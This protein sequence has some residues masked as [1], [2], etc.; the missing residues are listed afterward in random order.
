MKRVTRVRARWMVIGAIALLGVST[1][2][3]ADCHSNPDQPFCGTEI[4]PHWLDDCDQVQAAEKSF[5]ETFQYQRYG[6]IETLFMKLTQGLDQARKKKNVF[7]EALM[8]GRLGWTYLWF[9]NEYLYA[10]SSPTPPD[11]PPGL[12]ALKLKVPGPIDRPLQTKSL[13]A[14]NKK[15]LAN[16]P[17]LTPT[18]GSITS[19]TGVSIA[20]QYFHKATMLIMDVAANTTK[21]NQKQNQSS[22]AVNQKQNWTTAS[23]PGT[24]QSL[25]AWKSKVPNGVFWLAW[26]TFP[27]VVTGF[28][29]AFGGISMKKSENSVS[30]SLGFN[31]ATEVFGQDVAK[32]ALGKQDIAKMWQMMQLAANADVRDATV[33]GLPKSLSRENSYIKK[34][35]ALYLDFFQNITARTQH[36]KPATTPIN[37]IWDKTRTPAEIVKASSGSSPVIPFLYENNFRVLGDSMFAT[38]YNQTKK[39]QQKSP[40]A[41]QAPEN[42]LAAVKLAYIYAQGKKDEEA[43]NSGR[44]EEWPY[45]ES[46]NNRLKLLNAAGPTDNIARNIYYT[47]LYALAQNYPINGAL[48]HQTKVTPNPL[49]HASCMTCHQQPSR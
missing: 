29:A 8:Y 25:P 9:S 47:Q 43:K 21:A 38:Y 41:K 28:D 2:S 36:K 39:H 6:N 40:Q 42:W 24:S 14:N 44:F 34:Q 11:S 46:I 31:F 26:R 35:D 33:L 15:Y 13:F 22:T 7:A 32:H 30:Y 12:E 37:K 49:H 3:F 48:S 45:K 20:R 18:K 4:S 23:Q 16:P 27:A 19:G 10:V 17:L 5:W 1:A